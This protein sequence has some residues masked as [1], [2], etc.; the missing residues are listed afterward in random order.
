MSNKVID[1]FNNKKS[2]KMELSKKMELYNRLIDVDD[3]EFHSLLDLIEKNADEKLANLKSFFPVVF[4]VLTAIIAF[5]MTTKIETSMYAFFSAV[6][7]YLFLSFISLFMAQKSRASY[8]YQYKL[9]F[10]NKYDFFTWNFE[11]FDIS[12]SEFLEKLSNYKKTGINTAEFTRIIFIKQKINEFFYKKSKTNFAY[13]VILIGA[14]ILI[15][16]CLLGMY[17]L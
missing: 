11:S 2:R 16:A 15:V 7:A 3:N 13:Y 6:L 5:I 14:I 8:N 1:Y 4:T 10:K 9:I 12:D 17:V